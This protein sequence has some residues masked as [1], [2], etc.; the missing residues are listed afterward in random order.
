[1]ASPE[2]LATRQCGPAGVTVN[3][4][5]PQIRWRQA[6]E[7]ASWEANL[8]DGIA[9]EAAIAL[10]FGR[11]I[12][13]VPGPTPVIARKHVRS[14]VPCRHPRR[15]VSPRRAISKRETDIIDIGRFVLHPI[16]DT[17]C[18]PS[19]DRSGDSPE[20]NDLLVGRV[21]PSCRSRCPRT[22]KLPRKPGEV[23]GRLSRP[24]PPAVSWG[25]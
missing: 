1:V 15:V 14:S 25:G 11:R 10:P 9:A 4:W 18:S 22:G 2:G 3:P 24:G 19:P 7:A 8:P 5:Q 12:P 23:R 17:S 20:G 16:R 13:K 21:E 6:A